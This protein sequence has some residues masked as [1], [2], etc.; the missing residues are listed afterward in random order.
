MSRSQQRKGAEGERELAARLHRAGYPVSWGGSMTYGAVPDLSGLPGIHIEVKRRERL[1][2]REA[3][4]QAVTDSD[5]FQDGAPT[6][7]HRRNG[8][9]WLVTMRLSEWLSLYAAANHDQDAHARF[10]KLDEKKGE[11]MNFWETEKPITADTG[12]NLLEYFPGARSL[13]VS[14]PNWVNK[15]GETKRGKTVTLDLNALSKSREG[16]ELFTR[17]LLDLRGQTDG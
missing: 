4:D 5:R 16:M 8:Q 11:A 7:F 13:S 17:V 10:F 1:N 3:M 6:V 12:R 9:P 2:L 14:K 15:D